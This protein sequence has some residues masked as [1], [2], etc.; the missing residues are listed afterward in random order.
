MRLCVALAVLAVGCGGETGDSFTFIVEDNGSSGGE[1]GEMVG[2][3][4]GGTVELG[5]A[6]GDGGA[7][8]TGGAPG[9]G[10]IVPVGSGGQEPSTGGA[11]GSG[12]LPATGGA[13]SGGS[14]SGG[15]PEPTETVLWGA[16]Y[17]GD[18]VALL[19]SV[20]QSTAIR[21]DGSD[22]PISIPE[23]FAPGET[24]VYTIQLESQGDDCW[25]TP[26]QIKV[27][28]GP[29]DWWPPQPFPAIVEPYGELFLRFTLREFT[30][31][32]W[33]A[34][35]DTEIW[36]DFSWQLIRVTSAQ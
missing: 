20:V 1:G 14:G 21:L 33:P 23:T 19:G 30:A 8:D 34:E 13:P 3:D 2:S 24:G 17:Q 18:S 28:F 32:P 36:L 31:S 12:G 7:S 22:C 11:V 26:G 25:K 10:G 29:R 4:T 16:H 5:G 27:S 6:P 15:A 9:A 35:Y